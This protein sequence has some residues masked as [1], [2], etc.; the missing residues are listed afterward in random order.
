MH[1]IGLHASHRT[2][3][4]ASHRTT[5][6]ASACNQT[7]FLY[8]KDRIGPY[9]SHRT[10]CIA[11]DYMHRIGLHASH[12]TTCIASHRF[13]IKLIFF[14]QTRTASDHMHSIASDHM[15]SIASDH[16]HRIASVC[17]QADLFCTNKNSIG[18][19]APHRIGP[20]ASVCNPTDLFCTFDDKPMRCGAY[21]PIMSDSDAVRF[22]K[23]AQK[24]KCAFSKYFSRA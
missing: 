16:M 17:N 20:Y 18:P 24:M 11:S 4:T 19:Y 15:H 10:T 9:A 23:G 8:K 13:V 14:V 7:D 2:I 12:R 5:C 22:W 3:C 6:I 1:R 21:G